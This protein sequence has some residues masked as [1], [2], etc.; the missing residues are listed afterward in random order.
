MSSMSELNVESGET[1]IPLEKCMLY[2]GIPMR[3]DMDIERLGESIHTRGQLEPG[4]AI[5][6]N[7]RYLVPDGRRRLLACR[8]SRYHYGGPNVY[9]AIVYRDLDE[10]QIFTQAF[11]K[12]NERKS[13]SLLEEV[14]YFREASKRFGSKVATEIGLRAG[15]D[16]DHMKGVLEACGWIEGNLVKLHRIEMRTGHRFS[17][18]HLGSIAQYRQDA[19]TFYQIAAVIAACT[20]NPHNVDL[21]RVK[22]L[23]KYYVPWFEQEFPEY[24]T[25]P[26][27]LE[28]L[29][30]VNDHVS[31]N[32]EESETLGSRDV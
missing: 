11:I 24:T 5:R 10:V 29:T 15:R 4:M 8:Y 13:F 1:H 32:K 12:N 25:V 3:L 9:S 17:L 19:K 2:R 22:S 6:Q 16:V 7:D 20:M 28:T 27:K 23:V 30:P 18:S 31:V 26:R 21:D 14:N